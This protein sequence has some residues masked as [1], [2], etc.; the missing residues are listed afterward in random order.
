MRIVGFGL[1]YE[2]RGGRHLPVNE[3]DAAPAALDVLGHEVYVG[4]GAVLPLVDAVC[5][6]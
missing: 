2:C 1:I 3:E 6:Q 5:G 4:A